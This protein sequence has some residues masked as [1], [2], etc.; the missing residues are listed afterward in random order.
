MRNRVIGSIVVVAVMAFSPGML[1]HTPAGPGAGKAIP[2]LTGLWEVRISPE[3]TPTICGDPACRAAAGLAQP[4][5]F[6][7]DAEEPPM[8]PWPRSNTRLWCPQR[9]PTPS[10]ARL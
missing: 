6:T 5:V 7:R 9:T 4:R 2:D 10:P 8:L 3:G 1:A